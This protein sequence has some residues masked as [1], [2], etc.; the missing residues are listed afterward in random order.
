MRN[1]RLWVMGIAGML[2]VIAFSSSGVAARILDSSVCASYTLA[3]GRTSTGGSSLY[4]NFHFLVEKGTHLTMYTLLG[5]LLLGFYSEWPERRWVY[6]LATG[7]AVGISSELLQ[8][9][10]PGRDPAVRDVLINFT[11][12][13]LGALLFTLLSQTR[14]LTVTA[15]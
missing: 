14:S 6:T 10:F 8:F 2:L 5:F 12:T 15:R 13:I 11:G 7:F 3:T 9:A 4:G 1:R